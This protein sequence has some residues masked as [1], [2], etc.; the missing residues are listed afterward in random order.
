[1]TY[2][3]EQEMFLLSIASNAGANCSRPLNQIGE[4]A[5]DVTGKIQDCLD[6]WFP[7][8]DWALK[9]T[10]VAVRQTERDNPEALY[11]TNVMFLAYNSAKLSYFVSV[12]ATNANSLFD[13]GE[14][15]AVHEM[16]PWPYAPPRLNPIPKISAGFDQ[17]LRLLQGMKSDGDSLADYLGKHL[18]N[19]VKIMTGGHSQGGGLSPLV[20][21][22]LRDTQDT[23]DPAHTVAAGRFSCFRTAGPTAGDAAFASYYNSRVPNTASLVNPLDVATKFFNAADMDA[24]PELYKPQI[25]PGPEIR[26]AVTALKVLAKGNGYTQVGLNQIIRLDG[27]VDTSHIDPSKSDCENFTSQMGYQHSTAYFI[28]VGLTPPQDILENQFT[29]ICAQAH[30]QA[31]SVAEGG[32]NPRRS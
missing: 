1:M 30:S 27:S 31:S 4:L 18:N 21:L 8:K 11:A 22:W 9:W 3:H 20:A 25:N 15:F 19:D 16:L 14:D 17:G 23:W 12:A 5:G 32:I 7:A 24:I 13:I 26:A 10:G 2:T 6:K 28:L 29:A